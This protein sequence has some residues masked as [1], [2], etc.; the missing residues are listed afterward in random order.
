M[1]EELNNKTYCP[2]PSICF[3][4]DKPKLREIF[5][6]DFRDRVVH[7]IL[8]R[9]LSRIFEPKFIYDSYSCRENK[10]THKAIKR[11]QYFTRSITQNNS[12]KAYFLQLDIRSYFVRLNKDILMSLIRKR[13]Q[14]KEMLWLANTIIYNDC[15]NNCLITRGKNLFQYLPK[16]KTLFKQSK[17]RGIPVGNLSSQ[18]FANLYLNELD[19]FIKHILKCKYYLRYTDDLVMLSRDKNQLRNWIDR[20]QT[21]LEKHLDLTLNTK[22]TIILSISNGINYLGYIVRPFYILVRKRVVNNLK[23]KLYNGKLNR[24]SYMSYMGHFKHANSFKLQKHINN[25][26]IEHFEESVTG[27]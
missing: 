18:F 7:H 13:I 9:Y 25:M 24:A 2:R 8:V 26:I 17:N 23:N 16:H 15:T 22:K 12:K 1:Q 20:I 11:L 21:F 4:V 5:A 6:A 14:D 27:G 10:G 19:Q 3:V